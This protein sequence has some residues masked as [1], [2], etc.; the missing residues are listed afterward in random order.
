MKILPKMD[1]IKLGRMLLHFP[2]GLATVFII[3]VNPVLALIFGIG[4]LSYEIIEEIRIKDKGWY[5][6]AGFLWGILIG[7]IIYVLVV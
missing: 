1:L 4:F 2:I 6:I 7:S 3:F 5:D